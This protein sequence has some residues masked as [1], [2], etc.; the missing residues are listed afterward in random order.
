MRKFDSPQ[1]NGLLLVDKPQGWTSH[2][3]VGMVRRRFQQNKV[4]HSGT[5]D[6]MATGLL[7]VLIGKG[8]KASD[9]LMAQRKIYTGT[10]KLGIETNTQ[11]AEGE[12][13]AKYDMSH[14]TAEAILKLKEQFSGPIMQIPPMASALKRDGKTLYDLARKGIEIE[15]EPRPVTIYD[16]EIYNIQ[17]M[18]FDIRVTCSKGTYIRTIAYDMGKALGGGAHLCALRREGSGGYM[19]ENAVDAETLKE[20]SLEQ[21]SQALLPVPELEKRN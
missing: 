15:R 3:V 2:N 11:D 5:L 1:F 4:G 7:V 17:E 19:V 8:T 18:Q 12:I 13:T 6:P 20:W 10:V 14:V 9:Q 21:F 16:L